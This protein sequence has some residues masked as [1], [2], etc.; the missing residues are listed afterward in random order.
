M[1]RMRCIRDTTYVFNA[2]GFVW[3]WG[4]ENQMPPVVFYPVEIWTSLL[5]NL[6]NP[7]KNLQ[8]NPR[9]D[10][11]SLFS[12]VFHLLCL[13]YVPR[14]LKQEFQSHAQSFFQCGRSFWHFYLLAVGWQHYLRVKMKGMQK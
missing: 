6:S 5:E 7:V 10:L 2:V 3:V 14:I 13:F 9:H 1:S 11:L 8:R 12:R 4:R